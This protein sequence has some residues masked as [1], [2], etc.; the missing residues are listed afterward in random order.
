MTCRA[1]QY[2]DQMQ[3]P[4]GLTWDVNDVDPPLCP[5]REKAEKKERTHGFLMSLKES[6]TRPE[7]YD[8]SL[9]KL[10]RGSFPEFG[11][12]EGLYALHN[13][14]LAMCLR[15]PPANVLSSPLGPDYRGQQRFYIVLNRDGSADQWI[16]V[17]AAMA[18]SWAYHCP[19]G[20]T[21]IANWK[22][23]L[24]PELR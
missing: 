19:A 1:R 21:E 11:I 6:I 8:L 9:N 15:C 10:P 2:S 20:T 17:G 13:G 22:R 5:E 3:C 14:Q 23:G 4:C 16:H 24:P 18:S 7:G 12:R